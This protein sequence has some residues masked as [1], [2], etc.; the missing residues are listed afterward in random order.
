MLTLVLAIKR[1]IGGQSD[2]THLN[3]RAAI[4]TIR[5]PSVV[6]AVGPAGR[7]ADVS[8]MGGSALQHQGFASD[9]HE[10]SDCFK[11]SRPS[12]GSN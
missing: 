3:P 12:P 10:R 9:E 8:V 2:L 6:G 11:I 5:E 1:G 7:W 4:D